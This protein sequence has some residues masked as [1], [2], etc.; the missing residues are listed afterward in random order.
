MSGATRA[1]VLKPR[2]NPYLYHNSAPGIW[3]LVRGLF[4]R[5]CRFVDKDGVH[6]GLVENQNGQDVITAELRGPHLEISDTGMPG[7]CH[8]AR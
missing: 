2:W 3:G 4:M 8:P 7:A 1:R 6:Y 5:F